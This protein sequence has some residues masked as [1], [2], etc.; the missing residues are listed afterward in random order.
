MILQSFVNKKFNSNTFLIKSANR[1][2][3]CYLID[4][5]NAEDVLQEV[6]EPIIEEVFVIEKDSGLLA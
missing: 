4:I 6:F 5:G 2:K 3:D 1:N